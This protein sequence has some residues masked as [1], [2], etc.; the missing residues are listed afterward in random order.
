VILIESVP[1]TD[2]RMGEVI[3]KR[4]MLSTDMMGLSTEKRELLRE[5]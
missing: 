3:P 5:K 4:E 1:K 2:P